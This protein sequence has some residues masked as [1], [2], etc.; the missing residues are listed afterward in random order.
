MRPQYATGPPPNL[1]A[2]QHQ[3]P[4]HQILS[5]ARG[6]ASTTTNGSP[7]QAPLDPRGLP[8][9]PRGP[10]NPQRLPLDPRNLP[11][12]HRDNLGHPSRGPDDMQQD[13]SLR[14]HSAYEQSPYDG[15]D[16]YRQH[17]ETRQPG[18]AMHQH[19]ARQG[20]GQHEASVSWESPQ[21]QQIPDVGNDEGQH[22]QSMRHGRSTGNAARGQ[23]RGRGQCSAGKAILLP[24]PPYPSVGRGRGRGRARSYEGQHSGRGYG[25]TGSG[26]GRS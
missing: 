1:P 19:P 25:R 10:S 2:V 14:G 7:S 3:S 13:Y 23:G 24:G 12:S 9:N 18:P 8:M 17:S 16:D 5:P 4:A 6:P 22:Q 21:H 26:R 11:S 20:Q 15:R